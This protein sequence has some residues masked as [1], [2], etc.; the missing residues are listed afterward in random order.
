MGNKQ[1]NIRATH[2]FSVHFVERGNRILVA[3]RVGKIKICEKVG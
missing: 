3:V 1:V 2:R